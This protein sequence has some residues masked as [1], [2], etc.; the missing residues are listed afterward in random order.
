MKFRM[1]KP[2]APEFNEADEANR[3]K[4]LETQAG[5]VERQRPPDAYWSNL[6]IRTNQRI[7]EA[8]SGKALSISW[9]LRVALP[10]VLAIVSFLI[11]LHYY[12][13]DEPVP[14]NSLYALVQA[15]PDSSVDSL[16]VQTGNFDNAVAADALYSESS[17]L[18]PEQ[19]ADYFIMNGGTSTVLETMNDQQV[20]ALLATLYTPEK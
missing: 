13:P 14:A 2:A 9:A 8:T 1:D 12:V 5:G 17:E 20:N 16:L 19:I 3:L 10:G 7:D 15:M 6:L 4:A 18:P 11:G